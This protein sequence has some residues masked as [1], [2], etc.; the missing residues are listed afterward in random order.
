MTSSVASSPRLFPASPPPFVLE[1]PLLPPSPAAALAAPAAPGP[2]PF[3]RRSLRPLWAQPDSAGDSLA[4]KL[5]RRVDLA[6]VSAAVAGPS[7][8]GAAQNLFKGSMVEAG[9]LTLCGASLLATSMGAPSSVNDALKDELTQ[10][11]SAGW[12]RVLQQIN[13]GRSP[14]VPGRAIKNSN[15]KTMLSSSAAMLSVQQLRQGN[16]AVAAVSAAS[17]LL[18]GI[19]SRNETGQLGEKVVA[20]VEAESGPQV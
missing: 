19:G 5:Q 2:S 10:D 13:V 11:T 4:T 3:A 18:L 12:N 9:I 20:K 1:Q 8:L 14:F 7:L 16:F 17:S 6:Q 15:L